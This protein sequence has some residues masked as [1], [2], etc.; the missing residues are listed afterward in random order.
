M[1]NT[2]KRQSE[3]FE[4]P[5]MRRRFVLLILL[6]LFFTL[7]SRAVYIQ[8]MQK[9]FLQKEGGNRSNRIEKL[10]AYRGRILDRNNYVFAVSTPVETIS[11]N[12][13]DV[14]ITK[15]QRNKLASILDL[16]PIDLERRLQ[17]KDTRFVYLKKQMSPEKAA[18]IM[19]LKIPGIRSEKEYK[20][21]YPL[22]E[23][24]AHVIGFSGDDGNGQEGIELF[25][26]KLLAGEAGYKKILQDRAG[27]I[28]DDLQDVKVPRDG[29]DIILSID[30]RLQD[31]AYRALEKAVEDHAAISGSAILLDAK[32]GEILAMTNY[33]SY[34][35]NAKRSS[36]EFLRNRSVTDIFEP[37]STIKPITVSAALENKSIT[38]R[39]IIDTSAGYY[40]VGRSQVR[41]THNNG[42]ISVKEVIQKSSNIG[43]ILIG[44][45]VQP[46]NL[47][48]TL[49]GFGFGTKTG[50]NFPGEASGRLIDYKDWGKTT[51]ISTSYGYGLSSSLI[52]LAQS[53]T[54]FANQGEIKPVSII[55]KEDPAIGRRVI[56]KKTSNEM[57]DMMESVV[58]E[59]TALQAKVNG[60]RVAGKT[61]TARKIVDGQYESKYIGSFVGVAP[62]SDPRFVLAIMID[63]PTQGGYYGGVVAGPA[64]SE[65]MA[66]A[67][68]I[69]SIP[70]DGFTDESTSMK[71]EA[72]PDRII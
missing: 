59:G 23:I 27:R 38:P 54:V 72:E 39:T 24:A 68:K 44:L 51:Q 20:R 28:V 41:D 10:H 53:Y 69:Y 61:G 2:V 43:A 11:A 42:K 26:N 67:L 66:E 15:E 49:N 5:T 7:F 40:S 50:I 71:K 21:A 19:A 60:Y 45:N 6:G 57:L 16:N 52:Q 56:S 65:I 47:W 8:G 37:G 55:K 32:S 25:A 30:S 3:F 48:D 12:P 22:K 35:P 4:L 13:I 14:V 64:F 70:Q 33:P 31:K 63:E 46:K 29:Q 17:K 62:V 9:D 1:I 58:S 36:T 18:Q 34:N